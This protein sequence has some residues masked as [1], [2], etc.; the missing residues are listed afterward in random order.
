MSSL[1]PDAILRAIHDAWRN[2]RPGEIA[3]RIADH[4]TDDVVMV[5]PNLIR[6]TRGRAQVAESYADFARSA[7]VF[8]A[9]I[10]EPAIDYFGDELAVATMAW[11][12][13]YYFGGVRSDETGHDTYVFRRDAGRWRICWRSMASAPTTPTPFL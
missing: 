7:S 11:R 13:H 3:A 6:V 12:I 8:E 2:L 4:F 5:A 1:E 9:Q 10:D